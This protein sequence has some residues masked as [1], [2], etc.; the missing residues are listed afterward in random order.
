VSGLPALVNVSAAG[1]LTRQAWVTSAS[2]TVDLIPDA[3]PFDLGFYR[4]LVRDGL[5][6]PGALQPLRLLGASPSIY[7]QRA[8]LTDATVAAFEQAARG[9]VPAL[10][11]GRLAVATFASG[12]EARPT[13]VGWI[14]AELVSDDVAP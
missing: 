3:A 9:V 13:A 7:L 11:G 6:S 4:Q 8:G 1:H 2:P 14:V 10:T 12:A 5:E